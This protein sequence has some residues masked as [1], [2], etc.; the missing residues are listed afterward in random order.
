MVQLIPDHNNKILIVDDEKAVLESI[1]SLLRSKNYHCITATGTQEAIQLI[2]KENPLVILTD[3][4][5]ETEHSGFDVLEE[6][7]RY[8]PDAVVLL[9]TGYGS[10]P[11]AVEAFKKGAFDFIQKV[12]THHDILVPIERAF[13]F[14]RMQKENAYLKSRLNSDDGEFYG[15]IGNSPVMHDLFERTKRTAMT[16]ATVLITGEN[17]TGKEIFARGVHHYSQ[18]NKE[19][20]IPVAVGTLPDNLLEDELFGHVKG[21]FTDA[22]MDKPGLFEAAEKG[23]IFLDEIGEVSYDMQ[24]KLLR[25]LQERKVRRLGS[26]QEKD[27]DIRVVSATNRDPEELVRTKKLREDLYYRLK[28]ITLHVPPLR[29]RKEDIPL[30]AYHFLNNR[31]KNYG[32]V[33]VE[34]ISS[35]ALLLLQQYDWPGN[36]RELISVIEN[37]VVMAKQ[38][39]IRPED[40]PEFLRPSTK[41]IIVNTTAGMDFKTAKNHIIDAFETDYIE[42]LLKK[43]NYNISKVA[44]EAGLNRKTIYR[45][46]EARG[47]K[48]R[49]QQNDTD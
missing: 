26:V 29:E 11:A 18:R 27:I 8:D 23:T 36:V 48:L 16:N 39:E 20:F 25:V 30:L 21:A 41:R 38:P 32:L 13:K 6:V 35:D 40:L 42:A 49:E 22:K 10:V 4:K 15:A 1:I 33:E 34:T 43:H 9:Y 46:V 3:L 7:K 19:P 14:A 12:Q 45:L 17:G 47:I 2:K 37:A 31:F 24:H 5:M 28:V 44:R